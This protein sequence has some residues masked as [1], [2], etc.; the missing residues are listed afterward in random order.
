MIS[1]IFISFPAVQIY[2]LSYI[3][4]HQ[5]IFVSIARVFANLGHNKYRIF[6]I[7]VL[8]FQFRISAQNSHLDMKLFKKLSSPKTFKRQVNISLFFHPYTGY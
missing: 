3:H 8:E 7:L 4:L 2:D 6:R 5:L 1:H